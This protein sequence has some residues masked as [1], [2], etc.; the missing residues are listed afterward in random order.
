MPS[1]AVDISPSTDTQ[2]S[3]LWLY[4]NGRSKRRDRIVV[5]CA[6]TKAVN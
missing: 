3:G 6:L 5:A 2:P 1:V 4:R